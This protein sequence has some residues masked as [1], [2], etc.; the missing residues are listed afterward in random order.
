MSFRQRAAVLT[1]CGGV[2]TIDRNAGNFA[3]A[4]EGQ[5][6]LIPIPHERIESDEAKARHYQWR[7]SHRKLFDLKDAEGEPV[8]TKSGKKVRVASNRRRKMQQRA[9]EAKR[10]AAGVRKDF[11]H[12]ASACLAQNFGPIVLEDLNVQGMLERFL[13]SKAGDVIKVP[14]RNTSRTCAQCGH[15]LNRQGSWPEALR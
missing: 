3:L 10:K 2:C 1:L 6:K 5:T 15:T 4:W 7:A 11:S 14:A 9:A 13:H 8:F 12:Q